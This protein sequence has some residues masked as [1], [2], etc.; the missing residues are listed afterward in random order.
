[1]KVRNSL[2]SLKSKPGAQVVRRDGRVFV[3]NKRDP[4]FKASQG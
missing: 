3:L 4:R 2:R 1:M